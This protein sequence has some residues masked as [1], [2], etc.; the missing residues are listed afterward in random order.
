MATGVERRKLDLSNPRYWHQNARMAIRDIYDAL[1]ELITNADDRYVQLDVAGRVEIEVERRRKGSPSIV[2]ALRPRQEFIHLG[3]R[4]RDLA[5]G[6]T[7]QDMDRKIGRVGDRVSGLADGANVRGTNSRGAK[8]VAILGGVRFESIGCDGRYHKCEVT[9]QGEFLNYGP[10]PATK[11][12]REQLGIRSGT[13]TLATVTV[14][15]PNSVP[16]HETL[17]EK[18][19]LLVSLRE[20]IGDPSRTLI[21]RD[22][23]QDREHQLQVPAVEGIKRL[24]ERITVPDYPDAEAKL[25]IKRASRRLECGNPR[26]RLGGVIVKSRHAVHE[27]TFFASELEH[28]PYA[29]WF[30]GRLTCEYIDQ[31]SNE[32]DDR[33]EQGLKPTER[34]PQL[35]VDPMRKG[36]LNREH[37]F[38]Q[39]LLKEALRRFRPLVEEERK[40]QERKRA[41]VESDDTR[42]RLDALQREAAKFM[43]RNLSE[44]D[45]ARDP[46]DGQRDT[47]FRRRGFSLNPP[48]TQIVLGHSRRFWFNLSQEAF[49]EYEDG[50]AVQITCLSPE[51]SVDHRVRLLEVHP[52][53]EKTLRCVFSARANELCD[54]TGVTVRLGSIVA[55]SAIEVIESER[56]KYADV[57]DLLDGRLKS[58]AAR[59]TGHGSCISR[60]HQLTPSVTGSQGHRTRSAIIP[61]SHRAK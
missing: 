26:F 8:D 16:Q 51:I 56:E 53:L 7:T 23:N 11:S 44:D 36:G 50:S 49:P 2:R 54:A 31:L 37:P 24:A 45:P 29:A 55:D 13:G 17:C 59:W 33:L 9:P 47:S 32:Y 48:Y 42:R 5:D 61:D 10:S 52:T 14:E 60:W 35:I 12:V 28:D 19:A 43:E 4:V 22:A 57:Q 41:R 20:V 27:S 38:V 18:L 46:N 30:C 40:Q 25:I 21:V 39:Q 6:M 58:C 1:A 15:P 34:N 3:L